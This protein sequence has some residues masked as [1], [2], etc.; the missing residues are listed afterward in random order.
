MNG[1]KIEL[2]NEVKS[3]KT[4][5]HSTMILRYQNTTLTMYQGKP[6]KNVLLLSTVHKPVSCSENKKKT[7]ETIEYYIETKYGVLEVLEEKVRMYTSKVSSRGWPLQVFY[8]V[9]DLAAINVH[10]GQ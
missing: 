3:M 10:G 1:I 6:S 9:L 4:P 2:T 7:P 8:N 5:L